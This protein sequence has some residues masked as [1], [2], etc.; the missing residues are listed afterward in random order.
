MKHP[1]GI[2][3]SLR[4]KDGSRVAEYASGADEE[5]DYGFCT[6]QIFQPAGV[7]ID[8]VLKFSRAFR[9]YSA[10]GVHIEIRTG[11]DPEE[12]GLDDAGQHFFIEAKDDTVVRRKHKFDCLTL[13]PNE[14]SIS[15]IETLPWTIPGPHREF[16]TNKSILTEA[17]DV[18]PNTVSHTTGQSQEM[19]S[20][21]SPALL[22]ASIG[23][24]C[25]HGDLYCSVRRILLR[26]MTGE[27]MFSEAIS[28][29]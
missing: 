29:W 23:R 9:T 25:F 20:S 21:P 15:S 27:Y 14:D 24:S 3:V 12:L 4:T 6:R 19:F 5:N 11:L 8:V 13:H 22:C 1:D 16:T 2:E 17:N 18:Q 7:P 28:A 26:Y 10:D